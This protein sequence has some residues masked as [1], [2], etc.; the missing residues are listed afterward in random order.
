MFHS[1]VSNQITKLVE[2]FIWGA[3]DSDDLSTSG[4]VADEISFPSVNSSSKIQ[5]RESL[6]CGCSKSELK[7]HLVHY[8]YLYNYICKKKNV[9]I[10]VYGC[11]LHQHF[12]VKRLVKP[13]YSTSLSVTYNVFDKGTHSAITDSAYLS[14][15]NRDVS[16][17]LQ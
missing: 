7:L 2:Q 16:K 14:S 12:V 3:K 10:K 5:K 17:C 6:V 13:C 8:K 9:D 1:L 15:H 4:A 11:L